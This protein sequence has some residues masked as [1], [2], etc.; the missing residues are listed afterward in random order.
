MELM[1]L[2]LLFKPSA[3]EDIPEISSGDTVSVKFRVSEA[4]R[5]RSQIFSGIVIRKRPESFTVRQ[6]FQGVGVERTFPF[7]SPLLEEVKVLQRGRVRRAKLYYLRGLSK[8]KTRAKIR[9]K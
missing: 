1:N 4:G 5:E 6:I 2:D 7:H 3:R 8:R 9:A